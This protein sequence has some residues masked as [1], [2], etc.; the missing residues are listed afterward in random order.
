MLYV[1]INDHLQ[2]VFKNNVT[3]VT[4]VKDTFNWILMHHH[5]LSS[6]LRAEVVK[7]IKV[8]NSQHCLSS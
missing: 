5:V 6:C 2:H 4:L 1:P 8:T 7:A 3:N